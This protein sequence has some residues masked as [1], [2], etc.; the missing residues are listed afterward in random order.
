MVDATLGLGGHTEAVLTRCQLARV[1]GIDRDPAALELAGQRLAGFGDRFTGVHAVYDELPDVLDE[2]GLGPV[3]SVLFDLGVS[4]MQLDVRER[5]FA[6]AEDAPLDMRMDGSSGPT[7]ADVLN[8][9]SAQE[10]TRVLREYGEERFAEQDRRRRR[11][12]ARA[13]ALHHLG[14][15]GRALVRRDPGAG[16]PD[17]RSP[18]QAHL[19]GPPHGG[20]RRARSAPPRRPRGHRRRPRRWSRGRRVLPLAGGPAG[21]AGVHRGHPLRGAAGPPG[22]ARGAPAGVPARHP[23]RRAAPAPTR[24]PPTR[25][26]P[27]SGCAPSSESKRGVR[28]EYPPKSLAEAL[29]VE[30]SRFRRD[31]KSMSSPAVQLRERFPR[32]AEE[33]VARA[34]LTVVPRRRVRAARMPFVTLVS[35]VLLGG[36]VGLLC[37]NTQMQQASFAATSLETQ[38]NNLAAREQTLHDDLQNLRDPQRL[39]GLAQRAGMVVPLSACTVRLAAGSTDQGCAP[40]TSADPLPLLPRSPKKP[41]VLDPAPIVVTVSPAPGSGSGHH[42][43]GRRPG[44]RHGPRLTRTRRRTGQDGPT[45]HIGN[46]S[47]NREPRSPTERPERP[48]R[49]ESPCPATAT[50]AAARPPGR[51][52]PSSRRPAA[53]A[54]GARP[55]CGSASGS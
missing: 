25:A 27:R 54:G 13:V 12:P 39:A 6:Y 37:F 44:P 31:P 32:L 10:L 48:E 9:Y 34:R 19:P 2:L 11:P 47:H 45:R 53:A 1:V 50:A 14:A 15:A 3:D 21:Q 16:P 40:A 8:T 4:S 52:G 26:R 33:A 28:H 41:P 20:Q 43:G 7:A 36:V 46:T 17:R 18:R 42:H 35:L 22:R 38:D 24:S 51:P 30:G 55:S 5:G 29:R 23:G 49:P